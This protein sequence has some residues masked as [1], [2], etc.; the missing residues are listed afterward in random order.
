MLKL[1]ADRD[2]YEN[3]Q[4]KIDN[5]PIS[6]HSCASCENYLGD[7]KIEQKYVNWNQFPRKERDNSEIFKKVQNGY[8]RLLQMI[9]FDL[10]NLESSIKRQETKKE[11]MN[12]N[13]QLENEYKYETPK[14][15][16]VVNKDSKNENDNKEKDDKEKE[17]NE[18]KLKKI[19]KIKI[20]FHLL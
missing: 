6:G 13:K 8:S 4:F 7:L 19:Q 10:T 1:L 5:N 9:N 2:Q 14:L 12:K 17:K 20:K 3:N 16:L 18:E 11:N 15:S